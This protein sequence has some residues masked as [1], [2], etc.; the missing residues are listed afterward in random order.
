MP[1][2]N[3]RVTAQFFA[4]I[5]IAKVEDHDRLTATL[6]RVP[7]V[8]DDPKWRFWSWIASARGDRKRW[9]GSRYIGSRLGEN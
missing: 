9:Q 5:L 2:D 7:I 6:E 1:V 4:H 8:Q 3:V